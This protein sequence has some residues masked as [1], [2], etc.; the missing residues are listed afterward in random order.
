[1]E[2]P[3][4]SSGASFLFYHVFTLSVYADLT[5]L[6]VAVG[7]VE[8]FAENCR[9]IAVAFYG[10]V[11]FRIVDQGGSFLRKGDGQAGVEVDAVLGDFIRCVL[12]GGWGCGL[13]S[14]G[15]KQGQG[16]ARCE[17]KE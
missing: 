14:H 2:F 4:A 8:A 5:A 12:K 10:Y 3:T 13:V 9:K 1:M 7:I 15:S 11:S 6:T 17:G 16:E